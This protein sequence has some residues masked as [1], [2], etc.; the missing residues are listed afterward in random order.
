MLRNTAVTTMA[1][2]GVA[3]VIHVMRYVLLLVN[4][5][6]LLDPL[7]AGVATWLGVAASA[8]AIFAVVASAIVFTNWLIARRAGTFAHR[9]AEDPRPSWA[10][11][12]GCLVPVVN[13]FWAPVFVI[14]VAAAEGQLLR[15]RRAIVTWWGVWAVAT[16]VS[17]FSIATSFTQDVQGIAD[18][19]VTTIIAYLLGLAALLLAFRVY[20]GFESTPVE[21][22]ARRWVIVADTASAE[23]SAVAVETAGRNPAA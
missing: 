11:R 20:L 19:T 14:E 22:P 5:T 15:L 21:R 3:A 9:G 2:L 7:V 10:L 13:L 16:A 8:A 18:N 1:V 17:A 6:K 23:E 4:R 12:V